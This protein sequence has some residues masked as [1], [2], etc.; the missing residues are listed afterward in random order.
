MS[1]RVLEDRLASLPRV[2]TAPAGG[3]ASR[4]SPVDFAAAVVSGAL[5]GGV[6][7]ALGWLLT[8]ET[9]TANTS[10]LRAVAVY[11]AMLGAVYGAITAAW[12]DLSGQVWSRAVERAA[13]GAWIGLAGGALAG[14]AA[15][16][17][18]DALQEVTA[19]PSGLRF[20]LLRALAW[21]IFGA[22]IGAAPGIAERAP[23]KISNGVLG[24]VLGGALGGLVLHWASFEVAAERD[25]R[26]LGLIAIGVGIGASTAVVELAR[27]QAWLRVVSG[28]M[29]GKE[30]PLY[31][32]VT[33]IGSSPAAQ[34]TLIKDPH[35]APRHARIVEDGPARTLHSDD[36]AVFVNGEAAA[37]RRLRDGDLIEI[38]ST[39]LQ[40][41]EVSV[42]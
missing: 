16:L 33:E 10:S 39:T 31:H 8:E 13:A 36:G 15:H 12:S 40:Y 24:G 30:F 4:R 27:R 35:V 1:D 21:A 22:G 28:G 19:D 42:D 17:L 6:A 29:A 20:Y 14:A 26:L 34:I 23:R 9:G 18:Y 38:G 7:I 11:V 41:A 3:R 37:T 32:E 5:V 25:A 2:N